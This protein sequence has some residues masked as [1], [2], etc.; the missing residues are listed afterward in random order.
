MSSTVTRLRVFVFV[1]SS[2][3][4]R[5]VWSSTWSRRLAAA[6]WPSWSATRRCWWSCVAW[7]PRW[8]AS[9]CRRPPPRLKDWVQL[10]L[11]AQGGVG[12]AAAG[13]PLF[14]PS[15][16]PPQQVPTPYSFMQQ[17]SE[18]TFVFQN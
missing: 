7:R 15:A 4:S 1:S 13:G 6:S 3:P 8:R 16:A 12:W 2:P 14:R 10:R 11:K 18:I 5:F 9:P 17:F